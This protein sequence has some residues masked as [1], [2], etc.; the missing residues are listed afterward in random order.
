MTKYSGQ[1]TIFAERLKQAM[2]AANLNQV[3]LAKAVGASKA[4]VSQYL[5]GKN[6]PT[7][8]R[9]KAMAEIVGVS[10][11]FLVGNDL[12]KTVAQKRFEDVKI[13][14]VQACRCLRKSED[15]VR[16][17]MV[18]GCDF[19]KAVPGK[20]RRLNYVFYPA[21]FRDCVGVERFNDFFGITN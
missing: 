3:D 17:M 8:N 11:D 20:G 9:V 2:Y 4:A 21:K 16:T 19:G 12:N 18:E 10:V 7:E 13:T 15:T 5:S 1:K 6:I 14:F